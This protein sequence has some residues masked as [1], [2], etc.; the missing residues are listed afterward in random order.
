[1]SK[2][3]PLSVPNLSLDILENIKETIETGWVSTGGR[4][5]K[6]FEEKIA[7]YVKVEKAVSCQ[8]G[9]A[10]LHLALKVLDIGSDDEVIVPTVTFIAAVNPVKYVG[11]E[12]I[13]MDC[14]DTLNMDMDKLEEF[15]ENECDYIDGK[16]INK[17]SK[18]TIKAIIIV[19]VFGNPANMEKLMEIKEKYNLKI[20]EDATEALGSYYKEGKY[21]GKYC[22]TIGD[23]GVYSFNANKIITTGGGGM[24]VSNNKELLDKVEFLSV[25]AKTDPL[26][27]IHDEIGYNYRMT[28]IQAAF[29]VSQIDKLEEFIETKIKNYNIYKKVID[30]IEGLTLLP[31]RDDTR[32]NHWFYSVIVDKEKYG[33]DRDELLRKLNDK[34]IQTRPLWGLIHKQKPYLNNQTYKIEKAYYYEKNLI[35]IPCSSNLSEEDVEIVINELKNNHYK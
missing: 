23:I 25:Q 33:I 24:V 17:K 29:G 1:M 18:K 19:H 12:P 9:T 14:D 26:Y 7:N 11:A 15:L 3:I 5:I 20:I 4:F 34:N 30:D 2:F 8:S 35:N 16:V 27:F 28:N 22:G 21:A 31:F 32:A 10:G 6:E 13:F